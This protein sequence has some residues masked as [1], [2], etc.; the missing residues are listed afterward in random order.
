MV[1]RSVLL[2]KIL[3][4]DLGN[5][6]RLYQEVGLLAVFLLLLIFDLAVSDRPAM[7]YFQLVACIALGLY[8][9][10]GFAYSV[11]G[12][13]PTETAFGGMYASSP[14]IV[15]M[16]NLL[17]LATWLV[18]L[19]SG[20]WLRSTKAIRQRE[21]EF[22]IIM[23]ATLLGMNFMISS[24][25]F[26]LL[27]LSI[28]MASLPVACLAAFDKYSKQSAEAGAKY[29][30]TTA[31]SSGIMIF[32]ISYLYGGAGTMYFSDLANHAG[33]ILVIFGFVFFFAGLAYKI[34]L[35]PFHLWTA[36]VYEGAPTGV[37]AHLSVASKAA[38]SFTLIFILYRVFG[39]IEAVWHTM[40]L[41]LTVITIVVGNLFA[42]RQK[43][44]KRF[45]AFSSVSQAGYI[46][47]GTLS[48]SMQGITATVYYILVYLFSNLAVFGVIS[49]LE[50]STGRTDIS[51]L[52]GFAK[53]NPRLAFVMMIAVFSLAG[54]P[55]FAGFF[56]KYFIF[57]SVF[58]RG[59]YVLVA[60]AL[61]NTVVALYYYLLI[62]KAMYIDVS[63]E[64]L[65]SVRADSFNRLSLTL[66]SIGI[67]TIGF[68][69]SIYEYIGNL[70]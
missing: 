21:G 51:A 1:G 5:F 45:F 35:A 48:G 63:D 2:R 62:V 50:N 49:S 56:S 64:P 16:K 12:T 42:L 65:A 54:V 3:E 68:L 41:V 24:Q 34:S 52:R 39:N 53:N 36:D 13:V 44:I 25:H 70:L 8:V 7:K 47:L 37:A 43:N 26:M 10:S 27:Y 19:Q 31:L 38:A 15:M 58:A 28:E 67:L 6:I 60:I 32:G 69:S 4:M 20:Q 23:L 57:A 29:V 33:N 59:D 66:C 17:G 18:F 11:F 22:Y 55:P 46:M 40:L 9:A 14:M 61:A 30:L